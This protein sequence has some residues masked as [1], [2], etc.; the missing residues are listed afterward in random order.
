MKSDRDI[1]KSYP[2][3]DFIVRLGRLADGSVDFK[4]T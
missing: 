4:S 3:D 1:G 2:V